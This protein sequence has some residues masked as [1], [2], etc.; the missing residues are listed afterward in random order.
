[1]QLTDH[2]LAYLDYQGPL[3]GDRGSVTRVDAGAYE[4]DSETA[5]SWQMTLHGQRLHGQITLSR[6]WA[7]DTAWTLTTSA[8]D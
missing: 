4:T 5:E 3:T 2:R 6:D 1:M 7:S 8:H